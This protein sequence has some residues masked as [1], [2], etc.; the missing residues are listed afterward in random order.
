MKRIVSLILAILMLAC[1][2]AGCGGSGG[3]NFS[4]SDENVTLKWVFPTASQTDLSLVQEKIN[5]TLPK[6]LAN[7]QIELIC[8]AA[9]EDK[10][11][12]WI[13]GKTSF[14]IAHSGFAM[15]IATEAQKKSLIGLNELVDTYAPTIKKERDE[16]FVNL[17]NTGTY[18]DELYAIPAIQTYVDKYRC[19]NF[20][21]T[22][23][24]YIDEK[25]VVAATHSSPHMT[26]EI[27][28]IM[29]DCLVKANK[30]GIH[31][32]IYAT[33]MWENCPAKLGYVFIG[34]LNSNLCY[35]PFASEVKIIDWHETD[36]FKTYIKWMKKWYTEG[37]INK[38]VMAGGV[39]KTGEGYANLWLGA[40]VDNVNFGGKNVYKREND[41]YIKVQSADAMINASH[42]VGSIQTYLSIPATA[43]NPVRAMKLLEL[44]RT[45]EGAE[46][47][48][49]IAFG[50][51]GTHYE[52]LSDTCI[53][54]FDYEGQ[55]TSSSKYGIAAWQ[56]GNMLNGLYAVYPYNDDILWYDYG[57]KPCFR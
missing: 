43:K 36:E 33:Y 11:A 53:K 40:K 37:Y 44:L 39:P 16:L 38:D 15:D 55:G 7:T 17:Y 10:W 18:N 29:D 28:K 24:K 25:A 26:E 42:E 45:K 52:K 9:M 19:L 27:Y 50:I 34:G 21:N 8:D 41:T 54:A 20:T 57:S 32:E 35:D 31:T 14:D 46:I 2:F 51:E 13:A 12:L 49:L 30:D 5:E 48:N 47:L 22:L 23:S 56:V 4:D 6:Y 1:V 3:N